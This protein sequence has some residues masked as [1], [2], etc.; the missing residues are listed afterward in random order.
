VNAG[1]YPLLVG[2]NSIPKVA[3]VPILVFWFG[4]GWLPPVLTAFL[5]RSSRSS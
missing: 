3:V 4:V 2:F 5:S 1:T